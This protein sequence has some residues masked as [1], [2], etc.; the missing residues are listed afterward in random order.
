MESITKEERD[1]IMAELQK[2]NE[3]IDPFNETLIIEDDEIA[4]VELMMLKSHIDYVQHLID[5]LELEKTKAQCELNTKLKD[6]QTNGVHQVQ[7]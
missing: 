7:G 3:S 6:Y 1:K 4:L 2:P 5:D